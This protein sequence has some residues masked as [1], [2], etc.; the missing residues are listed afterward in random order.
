MNESAFI[1]INN[2]PID[3]TSFPDC[4]ISIETLQTIR[5]NTDGFKLLYPK[6]TNE[7]L[8]W[9]VQQNLN[10]CSRS[11]DITYDG[12]LKST[13][14]PLL[15]KRLTT[16]NRTFRVRFILTTTVRKK[17]E[18][19][20]FNKELDEIP[21]V[22]WQLCLKF[23]KRGLTFVEIQKITVYIDNNEITDIQNR[24]EGNDDKRPLYVCNVVTV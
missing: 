20:F 23:E 5:C 9:I 14:V 21:H 6:L 16:S 4:S 8:I 7:A 1:S 3:I 13:L 24:I 15:C 22:G 17:L 2:Q 10:N 19:D 11:S 12:I 18:F